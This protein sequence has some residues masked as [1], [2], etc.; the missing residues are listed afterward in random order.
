MKKVIALLLVCVF[1]LSGTAMAD[2]YIIHNGVKFGMT[3]DE[4]SQMESD[5][6][7]YFQDGKWHGT[8][9]G[10]SN[11]T[12][13]YYYNLNTHLLYMTWYRFPD[14]NSYRQINDALIAKYGN[15]E[16]SSVTGKYLEKPTMN[17]IDEDFMP[18]YRDVISDA[19]FSQ[20]L[21]PIEN[22]QTI[23]VYHYCYH[24]ERTIYDLE[25]IAKAIDDLIESGWSKESAQYYWMP[26]TE[27]IHCVRYELL[28]DDDLEKYN[29]KINSFIDDL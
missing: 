2:D 3:E 6:G 12:I 24:H 10:Q 16:F 22:N 7:F 20:W 25:P 13:Q 18:I 28:A 5:G 11:S 8:V 4:V 29:K 23:L 19:A 21:V 15:T 27:N 14:M 26:P 9:A 1:L 17:R